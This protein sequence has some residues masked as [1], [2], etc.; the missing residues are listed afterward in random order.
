MRDT[1]KEQVG[2]GLQAISANAAEMV[3]DFLRDLGSFDNQ[4]DISA[5]LFCFFLFP[6]LFANHD[7]NSYTLLTTLWALN[8]S[9][10]LTT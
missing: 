1:V 10:S 5:F 6:V 9:P 7:N 2:L 4:V 8:S 3:E